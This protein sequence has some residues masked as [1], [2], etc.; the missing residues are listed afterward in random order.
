MTSIPNQASAGIEVEHDVT[1]A[2]TLHD[3]LYGGSLTDDV[4]NFKVSTVRFAVVR[5][6]HEA[7]EHVPLLISGHSR[8]YAT[9]KR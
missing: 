5:D 1:L 7:L 6:S 2:R 3:V 4:L 8:C 9:T